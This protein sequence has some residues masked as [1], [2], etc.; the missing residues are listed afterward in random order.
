MLIATFVKIASVSMSSLRAQHS[1]S[2]QNA[3]AE[4]TSVQIGSG[5]QILLGVKQIAH[6]NS[7]THRGKI[8]T[9]VN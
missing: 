2:V 8:C 7:D 4:F 1:T 9:G 6:A 3:C 5:V